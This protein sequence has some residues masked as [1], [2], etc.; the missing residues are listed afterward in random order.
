LNQALRESRAER[1]RIFKRL[2][3]KENPVAAAQS[4]FVVEAVGETD[5]RRKAVAVGF[6]LSAFGKRKQPR[7]FVAVGLS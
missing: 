1:R 5:A 6:S 7:K 3:Q 2:R 4:G